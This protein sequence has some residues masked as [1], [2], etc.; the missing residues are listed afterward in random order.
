MI[1][2]EKVIQ[3]LIIF[4]TVL[5]ILFLWQVFSVLSSFVFYVLLLGW[6]LYVIASAL[7]FFRP[8][9]SYY[10]AFVLALATLAESLSQ[11]AHYSL[12]W[13]GDVLAAVT[14]V[15]G[16]SAQVLLLILVLYYFISERRKDEWAWPGARS[17]V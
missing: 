2:T 11:P 10:L 6:V 3:A 7:T 1:S 5:G 9:L 15:L 4:S 12:L 14:L 8:K 17:Q 16:D 13:G